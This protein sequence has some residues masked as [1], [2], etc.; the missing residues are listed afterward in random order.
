MER[1]EEEEACGP[2]PKEFALTVA[3][4]SPLLRNDTKLQFVRL[5]AA[6][7]C[8]GSPLAADAE[9]LLIVQQRPTQREW[10]QMGSPGG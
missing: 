2:L 5:H 10:D 3:V 6:R 4:P 7:L 1:R 8:L 9:S